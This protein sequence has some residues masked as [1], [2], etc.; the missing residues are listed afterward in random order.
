MAYMRGQNYVWRGCDGVHFW[1][2]E[3]YDGWD[4]SGW[5]QAHAERS[6]A[7]D[8]EILR[9]ASGVGVPQA[10][11]DAYVMLRLAQL[12]DEGRAADILDAALVH[13][14]DNVGAMALHVWSSRLRTA[15]A[16]LVARPHAS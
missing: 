1:S 7:S 16:D 6:E 4:E 8:G 2:A 5:A 9:K 12:L 11:A 10:V 14:G 15:F 3:G 13:G